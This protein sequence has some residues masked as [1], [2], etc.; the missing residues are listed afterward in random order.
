MSGRG[1]SCSSRSGKLLEEILIVSGLFGVQCLYGFYMVFL[2][3]VLALG[4]DSLF[5]VIFAGLASAAVLLPFAVAFEK[6]KWP[7]K[8]SP[9]LVIQIVMIGLGGVAI[10]QAL[11]MLGIRKTS[12][13]IASAMPNLAPGLI[14]IIAACLSL[15]KFKRKCKYTRAKILGTFVCLSGAIAISF[16]KSS[17]SSTKSTSLVQE[18]LRNNNS[19]YEWILGCFYLFAGVVVFSC[20]AVLQAIALVSF[21]APLSLCVITSL[22]GSLFTAILQIVVDGKLHVGSTNMRAAEVVEIIVLVGVVMGTCVAFQTWC[23][24]KK[25]PVFVSIFSPIQTVCSAFISTVIFKQMIGLGS[26]AGIVLMFS[27][28]YIVLWAK[29]K[30]NF[31]LLE[32][33]DIS[34]SSLPSSSTDDIEKPFL[35]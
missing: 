9:C 1:G 25:G 6:K 10:F 14:F 22:M 3:R 32:S 35:S 18:Q 24:G 8:L 33:D 5:I 27:G 26:L 30:E 31:D 21:P 23:L 11:M 19:Y 17:P 12:P 7:R 2:D 28:L 4:V 29:K 13:A 20:N 15:E 34:T 16:L